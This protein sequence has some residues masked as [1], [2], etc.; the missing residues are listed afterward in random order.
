MVLRECVVMARDSEKWVSNWELWGEIGTILSS[1]TFL[2]R[3]ASYVLDYH[4]ADV[5]LCECAV[6]RVTF[7]KVGRRLAQKIVSRTVFEFFSWS[8]CRVLIESCVTTC[9]GYVI[10]MYFSC[11]VVICGVVFSPQPALMT[12]IRHTWATISHRN[13][14]CHYLNGLLWMYFLLVY[15]ICVFYLW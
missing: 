7:R 2:L 15:C 4:C 3:C 9:K 14:L 6:M 12:M 5:L 13:I 1:H 8:C 11:S 10:W